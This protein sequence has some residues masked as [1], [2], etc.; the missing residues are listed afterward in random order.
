MSSV[1]ECPH[2]ERGSTVYILS[3]T[4][5]HTRTRTTHHR[6]ELHILLQHS[7][8][9]SEFHST[10]RDIEGTLTDMLD[11]EEDMAD[12]YL[13]HLADTGSVNNL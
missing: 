11:S 4:H 6:G 13:T 8:S 2:R 5:T 1:H 10:V 9:L 7:K 12:M 3:Y